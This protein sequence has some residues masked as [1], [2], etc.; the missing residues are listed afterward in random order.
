[1]AYDPQYT[2]TN[3]LLTQ[4]IQCEVARELINNSPIIPYWERR[5]QNQALVRSIHHSTALEGNKLS[6]KET[7]EVL[8]NA[9]FV[10]PRV[11]DA[12][13]IVNYREVIGFVSSRLDVVL[14]MGFIFDLQRILGTKILA[15]TYLGRLRTKNAVII[16]SRSG[17]VVFDPPKASEIEQELEELI[18]WENANGI[19]NI[20]PLIKA[21]I[22]HYELVRI[23][24]FADLN[25][26]TARILATWSLYRDRFDINKYFS[27]EEF[28]DQNPKAYYDALD[29]ANDGDLTTWIEY[30]VG[31]VA[32]EL[33]YVKSQVAGISRDRNLK[34]KRGQVALNERQL[35]IVSLI[36]EQEQFSN[37]DFIIY[38]PKVSDDTILRDLKDLIEK[39]VIIKKGKTKAAKY[40]IAK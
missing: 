28:Y 23:H 19:N 27:L 3:N 8:T 12:L 18:R 34:S 16:N 37:Q 17:E 1:M 31:G 26:R 36:E 14:T 4:I 2:I 40:L 25:G 6:L 35:K 30:F 13:E 5:F 29:S 7:Q 15:D 32:S 24:P 38:F 9:D 20:H 22:L 21:A 33:E 39:K 10:T 11:R